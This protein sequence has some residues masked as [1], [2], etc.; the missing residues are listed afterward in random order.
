MN[1]AVIETALVHVFEL[2]NSLTYE[3]AAAVIPATLQKQAKITFS[4][5]LIRSFVEFQTYKPPTTKRNIDK[6]AV[7]GANADIRPKI[8]LPASDVRN[9]F[10]RPQV[11]ARKPNACELT[12]MPAKPA[13]LRTPCSA[14]VKFRSHRACDVT[15]L[16]FTF[17]ATFT[18]TLN[19]TIKTIKTLNFPY[20]KTVERTTKSIKI[21]LNWN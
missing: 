13:E 16:T 2:W 8:K 11:S 10:C 5:V 1:E 17:S 15:K 7:V 14:K 18:T 3:N 21:N 20:A 12:R 4:F 9:T 19:P 6:T